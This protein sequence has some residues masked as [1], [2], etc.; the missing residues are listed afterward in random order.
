MN[1]VFLLGV[2]L[3]FVVVGVT[4]AA[5]ESAAPSSGEPTPA[6]VAPA[7]GGTVAKGTERSVLMR[8]GVFGRVHKDRLREG[9][10]FPLFRGGCNGRERS[11]CGG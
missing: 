2:F 8:Q 6:G 1:R 9:G 4:L 3:L 11:R 10:L 7:D 5:S